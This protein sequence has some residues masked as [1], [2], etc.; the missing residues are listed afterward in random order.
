MLKWS[1]NFYRSIGSLNINTFIRS[2]LNAIYEYGYTITEEEEKIAR[3]RKQIYVRMHTYTRMWYM[4]GVWCIY[5]YQQDSERTA[6]VCN[7][8]YKF[9][10]NRIVYFPFLPC[11]YSSPSSSPAVAVAAAASTYFFLDSHIR[12]GRLFF[13]PRE[14]I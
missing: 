4:Y 2:N 6:T 9:V 1:F 12:T 5:V 8:V 7:V 11:S 3:K 13:W 14:N 10:S